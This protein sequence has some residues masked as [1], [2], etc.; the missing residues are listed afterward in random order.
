MLSSS[1]ILGLS[2]EMMHLQGAISDIFYTWLNP[3]IGSIL[4]QL[5]AKLFF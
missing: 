3:A 2:L 1:N 4:L 5:N